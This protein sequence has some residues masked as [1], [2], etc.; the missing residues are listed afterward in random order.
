LSNRLFAGSAGSAQATATLLS[1]VGSSRPQ[2]I[3][4]CE[5]VINDPPMSQVTQALQRHG[6]GALVV[7]F[8]AVGAL[9][10]G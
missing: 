5:W 4:R 3:D 7:V 2:G 6:S 10:T 9:K 8:R 1:L